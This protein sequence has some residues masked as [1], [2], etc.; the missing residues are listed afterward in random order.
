MMTKRQIIKWCVE[1]QKLK[2]K[3]DKQTDFDK[4]LP[5]CDRRELETE[6]TTLE[7]VLKW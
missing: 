6:V 7:A 2:D 1:S 5:C 3:D 4:M